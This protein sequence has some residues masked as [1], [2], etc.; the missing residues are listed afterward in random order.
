MVERVEVV[1]LRRH[2]RP[3]RA[4]GRSWLI[5]CTADLPGEHAL[6][7]SFAPAPNRRDRAYPRYR[8]SPCFSAI[9]VNASP[10]QLAPSA[11]WLVLS[12]YA[13]DLR[14]RQAPLCCSQRLPRD[15][16]DKALANDQFSVEPRSQECS[17]GKR[18]L[19]QVHA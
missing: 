15:I 5:R 13:G 11:P 2:L 8:H 4:A 6:P 7:Q 16:P 3:E 10:A 1:D 18:G 17:P 19:L 9:R 14:F 12:L